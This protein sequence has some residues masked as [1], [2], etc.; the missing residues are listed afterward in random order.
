VKFPINSETL[1]AIAQLAINEDVGAGDHSTLAAV[2]SQAHRKAVLT[3]KDQGVVAGVAM[4]EVVFKLVDP[5]LQI[6]YYKND[7]NKVVAGDPVLQVQGNAGSILTA[8]RTVLNFMQ[9]M[10]G[11]ASHTQLLVDCVAGTKAKILDTRKTT[12]GLRVLEK[13]A[14]NIGGGTNHRFGLFDMIMLKDNHIDYAG[15][16][17]KAVKATREYLTQKK[18]NLKI[19]VE[20]RSL[21]EVQ[22]LIEIGGVDIVMLDNMTTNTMRDAVNLVAG[23]MQIEASGGIT[24]DNIREVAECGVDFISIG[25][26]THT[27]KSLDMNLKAIK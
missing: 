23:K 19:E 13:W 7:G 8:E 16:I 25:A 14:V 18:L 21:K 9:R 6:E 15:G 22:E 10:S 24:V 20:T 27:V 12:P 5:S 4:A 2:P 11:I 26:L 1:K 3:A 17:A